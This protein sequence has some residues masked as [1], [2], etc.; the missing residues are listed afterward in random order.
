MMHLRWIPSTAG[1]WVDLDAGVIHRRGQGVA[2]SKK[3]QPVMKIPAPLLPHLKRWRDADRKASV[4][5]VIHFQGGPVTKLRRSWARACRV[6]KVSGVTP[7]VL[8]HTAATWLM[9]AGEDKFQTAGFL[10]M[11]LE[12][13]ERVYGHHHPEFQTDVAN[14]SRRRSPKISQET[15]RTKRVPAKETR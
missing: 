13:L 4:T 7:H 1:G 11:S 10:G 14:S 12:M 3:R 6:A 2:E 9:Q 15:P 5:Y 8:R